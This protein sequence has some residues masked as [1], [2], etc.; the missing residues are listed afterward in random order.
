MRRAAAGVLVA[1]LWLGLAA[2]IQAETAAAAPGQ[3]VRAAEIEYLLELVAYSDCRFTRNGRQ[4][5]ADRAAAH[6]R[7]KYNYALNRHG[8]LTAEQFIEHI[9]TKSSWTGRAYTL[10]CADAATIDSASWLTRALHTYRN[11]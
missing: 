11:D 1:S 9:A 3:D 6:M 4:Y 2:P 7:K 10:E 8:Q 5:S